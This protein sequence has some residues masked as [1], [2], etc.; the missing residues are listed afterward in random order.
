MPPTYDVVVIGAGPAGGAAAYHAAARGLSTLLVDRKRFPRGKICGDGLTPRALRALRR[1]GLA[2]RLASQHAR[3]RGVRYVGPERTSLLGYETEA[4]PLN[5][6]LVVPRMDLDDQIRRAAQHAGADLVEDTRAT[7][8]DADGS[9]VIRGVW[10]DGPSGRRRVEAGV[11]VVANGAAGRLA[12]W[13]GEVTPVN[14]RPAAVAVRQYFDGVDGLEPYFEVHAPVRWRARSL[15][16]YGWIFPVGG[17]TA[18][19]GLGLLSDH[20]RL[21]QALVHEVFRAFVSGLCSRDARFRAARPLGPIEGGWLNARM[22]DPRL[23]PPGVLPVGDA[24]GL[25]NVFTGEG[26]AYALE[27]GELAARA[28]QRGRHDAERATASYGRQLVA[29]YP[30]HWALRGTSRYYR[31]LLSLGPDL[32][33]ERGGGLLAALR[34]FALDEAAPCSDDRSESATTRQL[35]GLIRSR[36]VTLVRATNPMVAELLDDML[37]HPASVA[38]SDLRLAAALVR[39]AGLLDTSFLDALLAVTLFSVGEAVLDGVGTCE[40]PQRDVADPAHIVIGD[41]L[42]TEATA[43]LGRLPGPIFRLVSSAFRDSAR[44]RLAQAT[45]DTVALGGRYAALASPTVCAAVLASSGRSGGELGRTS[46]ELEAFARWYGAT[47]RAALELHERPS[48]HLAAYVG[49]CLRSPVPP[50]SASLGRLVSQLRAYAEQALEAAD[51]GLPHRAGT[52]R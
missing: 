37:G 42:V 9:G 49:E 32:I 48:A 43:V 14:S 27:S 40:A 3:I 46:G 31:W 23:A 15:I 52:W 11:T 13:D 50:P 1:M 22:V 2:D 45:Q 24:A 21:D 7:E 41:Y 12:G 44:A 6:G 28:A 19:V 29:L 20:T 47:R 25:V 35:V 17:T 10:L 38:G 39:P 26:I 16:G 30:H 34:R 18:N 33:E 8:L 51:D 36:A 5:F 4:P